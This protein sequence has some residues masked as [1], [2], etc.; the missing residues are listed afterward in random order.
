[1]AGDRARRGHKEGQDIKTVKDLDKIRV[2]SYPSSDRHTWA[3]FSK[4]EVRYGSVTLPVSRRVR[5]TDSLTHS[6]QVG[7]GYTF[8]FS[9]PERRGEVWVSDVSPPEDRTCTTDA[10]MIVLTNRAAWLA[11]YHMLWTRSP[12]LQDGCADGA[13]QSGASRVAASC[14][15]LIEPRHPMPHPSN[16]PGLSLTDLGIFLLFLP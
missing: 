9:N 5:G 16:C 13:T 6:V 10:Q 4:E 12:K 7:D 15:R 1:M 14:Q 8:L 3:S 2:F 11:Q